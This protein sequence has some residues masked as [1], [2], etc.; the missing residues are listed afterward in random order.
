MD[1]GAYYDTP[2][3]DM[4]KYLWTYFLN[5]RERNFHD[6]RRYH[7]VATLFIENENNPWYRKLDLV[8]LTVKYLYA[9]DTK[10]DR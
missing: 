9:M 1:S 6:G 5:Q 8:E 4:E 10:Y 2:Y 3:I 7:I